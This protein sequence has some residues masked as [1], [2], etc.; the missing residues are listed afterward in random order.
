MGLVSKL[1][2]VVSVCISITWP[3][4]ILAAGKV[5]PI[6]TNLQLL[7]R[8]LAQKDFPALQALQKSLNTE[9]ANGWTLMH[10]AVIVGQ[11]SLV[12]PLQF[13]GTRIDFPDKK[14]LSPADYADFGGH[15]ELARLLRGIEPTTVDLFT[16]AATND[17]MALE[18][19]LA[20]PDTNIN[21]RTADDKTALHLSAMYGH[22]YATRYLIEKGVELMARDEDGKLAFDLAA[23]AGHVAAASVLLEASAGL[24]MKDFKG[25]T[26]LNWAV[27][28]GDQKRVR[29]LLAKGAKVGEGCQN[30]LEVCLLMR[31][32]E[33]FKILLDAGGIDAASRRG[34]TALMGASK[35]G[36]EEV[37]DILLAHDAN[38][39]VTDFE[40]GNTPLR[41]AG[42]DGYHTIVRKL[43]DHGAKLDT[44]DKLGDTALIRA[45]ARGQTAV[46]KELLIAGADI[47]IAG[48][49][50]M[51]ALMW[52]I[53]WN[54]RETVRTLLKGGANINITSRGG[55][56]ALGWAVLRGDM[57][58]LQLLLTHM[59]AN[60]P[61]DMTNIGHALAQVLGNDP[62]QTE[63][64]QLL[65]TYFDDPKAAINKSRAI[66][67]Y[68]A[69][70]GV[71]FMMQS[72]LPKYFSGDELIMLQNLTAKDSGAPLLW[73]IKSEDQKLLEGVLTMKL[74]FAFEAPK[75][76]AIGI[77][78]LTEA[79]QRDSKLLETLLSH[80]A[81]P[82]PAA[83]D[84]NSPIITATLLGNKEAVKTLLA[85]RADPD[86][87][88]GKGY[89]ALMLA[90][91]SGYLEVVE[92]LL[93]DGAN[94]TYTNA[95][96]EDALTLA[97]RNGHHEIT[98]VLRTA[99]EDRK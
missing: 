53:Y 95:K 71:K 67:R 41:L 24:N 76:R 51:T 98:K 36:D 6:A 89:S 38:T 34:D 57:E 60:S 2:L 77:E 70:L 16:A 32:L 56:S 11:P 1:L 15:Q 17:Q 29:E 9:G 55:V 30:A 99:V 14:G 79:A 82:N 54:E 10:Y 97:E 42:E 40:R 46:V 86:A 35:R 68:N 92:P 62:M 78:A 59:N 94:P 81:D 25:W 28:S 66:G 7:Q 13:L 33:M 37:V 12:K 19:L 45:A 48:A 23:E 87:V 47:N 21:A 26:P 44:L 85:W 73:A 31:D 61:P 91:A 65:A 4:H 8:A 22:L 20:N 75:T 84:G 39:N 5:S 3:S 43:I 96:G 88:D 83:P 74:G 93:L 72:L 50:R 90:A 63:K 58:M 80:G 27:V 52:A 69:T 64:R 18:R 49:G